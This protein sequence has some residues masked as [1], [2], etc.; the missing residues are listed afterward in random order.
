M[1]KI[2]ISSIV[3]LFFGVAAFS[4]ATVAYFTDGQ[5]DNLVITVDGANLSGEIVEVFT[6]EGGQPIFGPTSVRIV[7]GAVVQKSVSVENTGSMG[8]YLRMSVEKVFVLSEENAGKQVDPALVSFELN[9]DH[10]ELVDGFYYY[11]RVLSKGE[12]T[13]PLFTEVKFSQE[14]NNTYTNSAIK[15]V[16]KAY[17]TQI[18]AHATSVFDVTG[19]PEVQ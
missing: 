18:P 16:I 5:D 3:M 2:L 7:P 6:P 14:M 12:T 8:M 11:K 17:A 1:K 4:A 15:F 19:W 9:T 13:E 10:W